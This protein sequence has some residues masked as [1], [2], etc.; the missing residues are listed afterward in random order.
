MATI[1]KNFNKLQ[2]GHLFEEVAKRVGVFLKKN[3]SVEIIRLGIGDT[4]QPLTPAVIKGLKEGVKRLARKKTYTG[5]GDTRGSMKLRNA[6]SDF[7]KKGNIVLDAREIFIS[8]GAK[9][10]S[11]N[12]ASIFALDNVV[13]ITDP[14]YPVYLDSNVM[15][16]R[17]GKFAGGKYEGV[18]YMAC[19]EKN[20]FMPAP[21]K[22]KTDI[23]YLCSPNNPTGAVATKKQ[24]KAFVDYALRNKAVIIFDATYAEYISLNSLPKSIY[25]VAGAKKCAIEINSF[26]KWAGFTGVRLG[27]SVVPTDLVIEGTKKGQVNALWRRRQNTMFNGASNISQAGAL[28]VLSNTGQ[29]ENKKLVAYYMENAKIIK[30]G[31]SK[32]GL[33]VFGGEHAPYIWL[34]A[35]NNLSSW[36]FFD[37]LLEEAHIVATPGSGFGSQGEGYIRLSTF[38]DR[39]DIKKALKSIE[40]NLKLN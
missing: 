21:P 5:Y 22:Q 19:N 2:G 9:S 10:D 29:K 31:L 28:S 12:I 24:L 40:K 34:K 17:T 1:N 27:W 7:Y 35:P 13:A 14:V 20:G 6:L 15:A 11:A 36:K 4:T 32:L 33:K 39:Q 3:P 25:E 8:D 37:K 23:I 16:G 26:S 18:V 38:G 30:K